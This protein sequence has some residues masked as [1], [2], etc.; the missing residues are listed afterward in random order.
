MS[1]GHPPSKTKG[2]S[3]WY[4]SQKVHTHPEVERGTTGVVESEGA[5]ENYPEVELG[6]VI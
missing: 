6:I 5:S 4:F 2:A 3:F 1:R